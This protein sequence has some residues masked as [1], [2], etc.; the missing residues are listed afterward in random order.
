MFSASILVTNAVFGV[1]IGCGVLL[2]LVC[3][4]VDK[5]IFVHRSFSSKYSFPVLFS[6]KTSRFNHIFIF[7]F[8][9]VK[10]GFYTYSTGLINTTKYINNTNTFKGAVL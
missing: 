3:L 10:S 2:G 1:W 7:S 9:S 4:F 8:L 6:N 5:T